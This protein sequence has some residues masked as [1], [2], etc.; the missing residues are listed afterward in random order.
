MVTPNGAPQ[1]LAI[2]PTEDMTTNSNE[3]V[4]LNGEGETAAWKCAYRLPPRLANAALMAKTRA[5]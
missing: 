5:L 2:P 1:M 3:P 4:K